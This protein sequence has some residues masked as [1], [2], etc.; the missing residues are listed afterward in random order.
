MKL[1]RLVSLVTTLTLAACA[2]IPF[3]SLPRL[4]QIDP[5]VTDFRLAR[6]AAVLPESVRLPPGDVSLTISSQID[7]EPEQTT[8]FTLAEIDDPEALAAFPAN[9][10]GGRTVRVLAL[11]PDGADRVNALRDAL[12]A[13][14]KRGRRVR[15]TL[16]VA[17]S[18]LCLAGG[19]PEALRLSVYLK[20][21]ET[22]SYVALLRDV[23]PTGAMGTPS[24][25]HCDDLPAGDTG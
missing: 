16:G 18:H 6:I 7:N 4:G 2:S 1:L 21:S 14:K 11:A 10:R 17:A 23:D 22:E 12:A 15:I 24:L 8:A 20:T 19:A 9:E 25:P 5:S 3:T 13:E